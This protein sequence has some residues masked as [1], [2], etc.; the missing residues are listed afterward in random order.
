MFIA[1]VLSGGSIYNLSYLRGS[2]ESTMLSSF[3][4]SDSELGQISAVLGFASLL[5]YFPGGW[6]A[7]RFSSRALL[8]A[9]LDVEQHSETAQPRA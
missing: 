8:S 9:S 6:L 4:L 5:C 7:D 2:F 3:M 1:L